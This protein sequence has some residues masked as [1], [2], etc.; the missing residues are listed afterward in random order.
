MIKLL[1]DIIYWYSNGKNVLILF[2][3]TNIV[4]VFMLTVTIHKVTELAGGLK[5][6]DM[7]PSGYDAGYIKTLFAALGENG[8]NVYLYNQ[9][10]VDMIYPFFFGIGYCLLF[11]YLL[12][13]LNRENSLFFYICFLPLIAA[14]CDYIENIGIIKMLFEYPSVSSAT[15]E[16]TNTF[17][18][19]KS[20][21]TTI[22]FVALVIELIVFGIYYLTL[23]KA[24]VSSN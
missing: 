14:I 17:S 11:V 12:K 15:V 16:I 22:F 24:A 9:I 2:I 19:V 23:R 3:I 5:I 21:T 1:K 10:P 8:R 4:Y 20:S 7:M 13:K 18:M 6:P